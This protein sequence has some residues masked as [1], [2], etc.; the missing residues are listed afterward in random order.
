MVH[1]L[2]D[3]PAPAYFT[4]IPCDFRPTSVPAGLPAANTYSRCRGT[5][6]SPARTSISTIFK[7]RSQHTLSAK[8]GYRCD[9]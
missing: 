6:A 4:H 9:H 2:A 5:R 3:I 8:E 1:D 7:G